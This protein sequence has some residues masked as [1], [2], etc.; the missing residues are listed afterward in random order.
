MVSIAMKLPVYFV[1]LLSSGPKLFSRNDSDTDTN[2]AGAS[3]FAG[4]G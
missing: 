1:N 2:T 4:R 3:T